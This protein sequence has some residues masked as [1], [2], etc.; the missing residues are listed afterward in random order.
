MSGARGRK[1]HKLHLN[2]AGID[3]KVWQKPGSAIDAIGVTFSIEGHIEKVGGIQ[4]FV[5]WGPEG[6]QLQNPKEPSSGVT[7]F[8]PFGTTRPPQ[9][10]G[11]FSHHGM[12]DLLVNY[13]DKVS[14]LQGSVLT[15]LLS[16]RRVPSSPREGHR[17]VQ[18]GDVV[19]ILNGVD[20]N[21]KWDGRKVS[22]LGIHGVPPAP[23]VPVDGKGTIPFQGPLHDDNDPTHLEH[24]IPANF[25]V[26]KAIQTSTVSTTYRY[27]QT[28]VSDKGQESESS[29]PSNPVTDDITRAVLVSS[30]GGTAELDMDYYNI[31]VTGL[32][33]DPPSDDIVYRHLYRST[34]NGI[35]K[36]FIKRLAGTDLDTFWD[37]TPPGSESPDVIANPGINL[38]PPV[39]TWAFSY[40]GRV[41]YGGVKSAPSHLFYSRPNGLQGAVSF[42]NIIDVASSDGDALTGFSVTEDYVAIFKRRSI[43][44]LTSS[45]DGTPIMTPAVKGVGAVSDL[46]IT[47]FGG[48]TYFLSDAGYFVFNGSA[49]VPLSNEITVLVRRLPEAYLEDAFSW[50]DRKRRRIC[51]CVSTQGNTG[52]AMGDEIWMIHPDTG[53]I[54]RTTGAT[55]SSAVEWANKDE[56]VVGFHSYV[57]D[58]VIYDGG[59]DGHVPAVYTPTWDLGLWDYQG[60]FGKGKGSQYPGIFETSWLEFNSPDSDKTFYRIDVIYSQ[61]SSLS[62]DVS[63]AVDWDDRRESGSDATS[64]VLQDPDAVMWDVYDWGETS[65]TAPAT[66]DRTWDKERTR[67]KRIN[68]NKVTAKSIR[69]KFGVD[70]TNTYLSNMKD[71]GGKLGNAMQYSD[72]HFKIVGFT[73]HYEDHGIRAEGVDLET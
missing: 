68:L 22:P 16:G 47:S 41:Y 58:P 54:T 71:K 44:L 56:V 42:D 25:Y 17:F 48:K 59:F 55:M 15:E 23:V 1:T 11:V 4:R 51:L 45:R 21:M 40:R 64:L 6:D 60:L 10:L 7:L 65:A 72:S 8:S 5:P 39:A 27:Y 70:H 31:L 3:T 28:W 9:S 35:S 67:T 20:A 24:G 43:Y 2:V 46:S 26:D 73:V 52:T 49:A 38:P 62:M 33:G 36:F 69:F 37:F 53:G 57:A 32:A 61:T 66:A 29:A 14:V 13:D 12:T 50:V 18:A 30:A 34:D 19:L 63:W